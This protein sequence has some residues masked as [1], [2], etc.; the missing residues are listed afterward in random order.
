M[1]SPSMISHSTSQIGH[2]QYGRLLT[3][4]GID[5]AQRKLPDFKRATTNRSSYPYPPP[6]ARF[7]RQRPTAW[8]PDRCQP[9]C[10]FGDD[11]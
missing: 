5:R 2:T 11:G 4:I 6:S 8:A 10:R 7:A 1:Q 9:V 3:I